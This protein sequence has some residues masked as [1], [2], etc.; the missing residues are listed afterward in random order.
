MLVP[1]F[2]TGKALP[3]RLNRFWFRIRHDGTS[4][5]IL[6]QIRTSSW[7]FRVRRGGTSVEFLI[8]ITSSSCGLR[9]LPGILILMLPRARGGDV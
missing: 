7:G 8:Q 6:V 1:N 4:V 3:S 5:E 9:K 2:P